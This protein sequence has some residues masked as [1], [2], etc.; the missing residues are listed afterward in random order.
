MAKDYYQI[1]E[2]P[3]DA[4]EEQ[5]KRSYRQL[6]QKWH[7]DKHQQGSKE[8][9]EAAEKFKEISE[10]YS[11]LSDPEKKANYDLTGD[12]SR[13][14]IH[15]FR[16]HGDPFE[17]LRNFEGFGFKTPGPTEPRPMKGQTI[18]GP[19]GISLKEA[20]FGGERT[21]SYNT[22]SACEGCYGQGGTEFITCAECKGSCIRVQQQGSMIIHTTCAACRGEGKV[23]KTVCPDCNGQRL[24]TEAKTLNVK[25]PP[26]IRHGVSLRIEGK[27]GRGF[28]GG[29]AGDIILTVQVQYPD[30]TQ[31]N[32]EE[33]NQLALL[34]SK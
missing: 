28:N 25:I 29:P 18:Q 21:F 20:L 1:L 14:N 24:V 22:N 2:V 9:V 27:G 13:G 30:L 26:E 12:P 7:P 32:E 6:A 33:K 5:L 3:R 8:Q 31:L 15:G 19:L 16:T 11:V 34:L 10:A 23:I 17:V 4:N